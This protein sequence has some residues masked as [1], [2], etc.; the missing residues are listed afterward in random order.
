MMQQQHAAS[1]G[2]GGR[3]RLEALRP[4]GTRRVLA[5]WFDN[6]VLDAGL[7]RIGSGGILSYCRVGTGSTAPANGQTALVN[8]V[9]ATSSQVGSPATGYDSVGNLYGWVRHTFRFTAGAAAGVLAEVGVGWG[10]A[11]ATLFSR[12]LILDD[13][14]DP[15]TVTVLA[16]EVLDVAYEL[17]LYRPTADAAYTVTIDGSGDHAVLMRAASMSSWGEAAR[18]LAAYGLATA[19]FFNSSGSV[20]AYGVGALGAIT[21]APGGTYLGAATIAF[22]GAYSNNSYERK[23]IGTWDINSGANAVANVQWG[24]HGGYFKNSF[25]P[26]VPKDATKELKLNFKITWARKSI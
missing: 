1:I 9:A 8:Q 4:D 14:G 25:D 10:D 7:N 19:S 2:L 21:A 15:T 5:D 6:L 11:G 23:F 18:Y 12:A 22:D 16:D 13:E 26:V 17:R 20:G 24:T 3:F